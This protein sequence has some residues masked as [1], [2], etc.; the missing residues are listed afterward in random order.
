MRGDITTDPRDRKSIK[1]IN[2]LTHKN[3]IFPN[4]FYEASIMLI[5]K[6][7]NTISNMEKYKLPYVKQIANGNLLCDSGNSNPSSVTT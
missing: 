1:N 2:N 7:N 4:I 3:N 5:P 6:N